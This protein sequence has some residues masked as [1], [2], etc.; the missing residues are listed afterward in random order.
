MEDKVN[1]ILTGAGYVTVGDKDVKAGMV[2]LSPKSAAA[3]VRDGL[4]KWPEE[5][6]KTPVGN[7]PTDDPVTKALDQLT[8]AVLIERATE[9]GVTVDKNSTKPVIIAAIIEL[10][11]AAEVLGEKK[12]L[13]AETSKVYAL[14]D[15]RYERDQLAESAKA[16]D[17]EFG[18]EAEKAELIKLI[19]ESGKYASL[20]QG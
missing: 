11:K 1:V 5:V 19:I 15:S 9:A 10:G 18:A 2:L 3:A 8:K 17:I 7:P 6:E 16:L 4:A 20:V 14:L 13:D 12:D